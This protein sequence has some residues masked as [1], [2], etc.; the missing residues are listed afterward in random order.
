MKNT[1]GK[2]LMGASVL[3]MLGGCKENYKTPIMTAKTG[4]ETIEL[5]NIRNI[6]PQ[7]RLKILRQDG[8]KI[9]IDYE[10][11]RSELQWSPFHFSGMYKDCDPNPMNPID[12]VRIIDSDGNFRDY[13]S[14][15]KGPEVFNEAK[16]Y[17]STWRDS[18]PGQKNN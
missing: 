8:T 13:V 1:L 15:N 14:Y 6:Y 9:E 5:Y 11:E 12:K 16:K 10:A 3:A 4:T 17:V 7:R 2:I 18:I